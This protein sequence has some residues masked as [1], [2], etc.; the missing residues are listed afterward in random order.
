MLSTKSPV[1]AAGKRLPVHVSRRPEQSKTADSPPRAPAW[2]R[3]KTRH[4][5]R[6]AMQTRAWPDEDLPA[7]LAPLTP[8]SRL[9][10]ALKDPSHWHAP[11]HSVTQTPKP[12][13]PQVSEVSRYAGMRSLR[14]RRRLHFQGDHQAAA[15]G[16]QVHARASTRSLVAF[17]S[18]RHQALQLL[19]ERAMCLRY[20]LRSLP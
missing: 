12:P 14:L 9:A 3:A 1:D 5:Q 7:H 20:P 4:H 13:L 6:L 11:P 8:A 10:S 2:W 15:P 18:R 19:R 16:G 17:P